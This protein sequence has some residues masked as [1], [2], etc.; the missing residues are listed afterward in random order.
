MVFYESPAT[1]TP[2]GG[3][4]KVAADVAAV[5]VAAVAAVVV[6]AA[7]ILFDTAAVISSCFSSL[8]NSFF[9]PCFILSH[10]PSRM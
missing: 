5:V 7:V 2:E 9:L 4:L 10:I 8:I 3:G 1:A 6:A